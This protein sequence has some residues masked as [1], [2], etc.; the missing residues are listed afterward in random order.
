MWFSLAGMWK[1]FRGQ[2]MNP[3]SI[4]RVFVSLERRTIA[5]SERMLRSLKGRLAGAITHVSTQS[6]V[7]ALT[8]DDGPHPEF[9]PRL[10]DILAKHRARAT[11]FVVGEAAS[12]QPD[13]VRRM[14]M[15]GHAIGNHSWN[16]PSFPMI[17]GRE[18][19]RQLRACSDAIAP[20]GQRLFRPPYAEQSVRSRLDALL[21]QHKV[22]MFNCE[23]ADWCDSDRDRM[24]KG[25]VQKV[26]PGSIICLHDALYRDRD[27]SL[28]PLLNVEPHEDRQAMLAALDMFLGLVDGKFRFVTVT[29]LLK[30]GR[31][32]VA[33][34]HRVLPARNQ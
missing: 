33:N 16:H 1:N 6:N 19:R 31:P 3:L 20:F 23:V 22:I 27:P 18:R 29:E 12:R 25:L 34:W 2:S 30:H 14:A 8:F 5:A 11:F 10:L 17:S 28:E 21:M 32:H 26:K 9:T 15:E 24:T 7:A 13:L 4:E